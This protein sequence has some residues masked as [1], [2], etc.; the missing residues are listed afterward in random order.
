[1]NYFLKHPNKAG[2]SYF[3][4]LMLSMRFA[5]MLFIASIQAFIHA[6]CPFLFETSTSDVIKKIDNI[7]VKMGCKKKKQCSESFINMLM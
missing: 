1:M 7:M 6:L 3:E 2:M 4:H 5:F